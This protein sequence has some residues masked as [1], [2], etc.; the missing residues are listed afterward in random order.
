MKEIDF[1]DAV[2][3]V[4]RKY[5][6]ECITYKPPRRMN[7]WIRRMSTLAA[8]FLVIIGAVLIINH[9]NQPV[10]IDENGFYIED[11][12][13]LRYTGSETDVTIP[14]EV[15][16]IAD[17]TFL[18]N[19]NRT[20]IEVV[21]LG[22]S[23]QKVETNA[24]AGLENL[25]DIIIAANNLSFVEEDGLL[26]TSDK[27][28]LL[29]YKRQ[30]ETSF[31]IPESVRFVAAHAVQGTELEEIDFGNI[32]Y[33]GYYAFT[34]NYKLKEIQL[35][36][37]VKYIGEGAFSDCTSAVDGTIPADA[38]VSDHAFWRVPFYNSM[39]AG[40]M[41]PGEEIRRGLITPSEAIRK[42]DL[43]SLTE[44]L[45]YVLASIRG[46]TDYEPSEAAKFGTAAAMDAPSVPE[47]MI[48]PKSVSIDDLTFKDYG[49]SNTGI[50]DLQIN[51]PAGDY[52]IVIESYGYDPF[53]ELYWK[54]TRFRLV[55]LYYLKNEISSEDV[56][57]E[58]FGWTVIPEKDEKTFTGFTLIHE[59]GTVIHHN[60]SY[61]P[62]EPYRFLFSPNGTRL[63]VEYKHPMG[64]YSFY[65]LSLNGDMLDTAVNPSKETEYMHR[66][67]G[68][69]QGGTL[70]WVD[71]ENLEGVNIYGKFR[72]NLQDFYETKVTQLDEDPSLTDPDNHNTVTVCVYT[73][74]GDDIYLDIPETWRDR[75]SYYDLVRESQGLDP[76]RMAL[77]GSLPK[78]RTMSGGEWTPEKLTKAA[79]EKDG[80]QGS[81]WI[82]S[83][84][85][86]FYGTTA[87]D[88]SY[89]VIKDEFPG[90]FPRDEYAIALAY[91]GVMVHDIEFKT[92]PE[93]GENAFENIILPILESIIIEPEGIA[94]VVDGKFSIIPS[95]FSKS[96]SALPEAVEKA[97]ISSRLMGG[98][99]VIYVFDDN[100]CFYLANLNGDMSIGT[101]YSC[102]LSLPNGYT[103]GRIVDAEGRG[104]SGEFCIYVST[105][106]NG[107]T[108]TL[109]Y[110]FSGEGI[111][112]P[113]E[114]RIEETNREE[115]PIH[116]TFTADEFSAWLCKTGDANA[117]P[118]VPYTIQISGF[119]TP[120][121]FEMNG[122]ANPASITAYDRTVAITENAQ[123]YG[124]CTFD[125]FEADGA[126]I[127]SFGYYNIGH[128]YIL[129]K[130]STQ[131][132]APGTDNSIHLYPDDAGNLRYQ[133]INNRIADIIQ[134]GGL[135]AAT[136]YDDLLYCY[137]DASIV[138]GELVL[139]DVDEY[140][141]ISDK[142]DLDQEFENMYS[143]YHASIQEVFDSHKLYPGGAIYRPTVFEV[144]LTMSV[145]DIRSTYGTLTLE[146]SEHGPGQPVYSM[147]Y[148]P[149][150]L[151]VFHNWNMD[152]P[153]SD[154][155]I[156]A[157]LILTEN[158]SRDVRGITVGAN[159]E[160]RTQTIHWSDLWYH[161]INGT[162]NLQAEFSGYTATYTISGEN[163]NLPA[164]DTAHEFD[165][166]TWEAEYIQNP[167]G[168]IVEI[169]I[170]LNQ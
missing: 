157:E 57:A 128:T 39:L 37:S 29:Q 99:P 49:W 125:L 91:Q 21:R 163:L 124:N 142:Y 170:K 120:V 158:C 84:S 48:V 32:E 56:A 20:K 46:D 52:T 130:D 4:D 144:L 50:Y 161:V 79:M 71:D 70:C 23:V 2:G 87:H 117:F 103:Y 69:Y 145:A 154:N 137:G 168:R 1:L 155:M 10:I 11:G 9:M 18:E 160:D 16:T 164:E 47:G 53:D 109:A 17:F 112:Q 131:T 153:L 147:K 45:T 82:M 116:Y 75:G 35:P 13:L 156:P 102:T 100:L 67:Y 122:Y 90:E 43:Y 14:E 113:Y 60:C 140:Y 65:I 61:R 162:A 44:Q 85:K 62:T 152:D 127:F 41:C 106:H 81:P 64:Y 76:V 66:Y 98:S 93:D 118:T 72:F 129:T 150:V 24:F 149:G 42:S 27:S 121:V 111:P 96:I 80:L 141:T 73:L 114:V 59:D 15:E 3:R 34:G 169:R 28:I 119:D 31:T 38:E 89:M 5:I 165:W 88:V 108:V 159:I 78:D 139:Q 19:T 107:D 151:L 63:A 132:I 22:A 166:D 104:G 101:L 30:G 33:I 148:L 68:E 133:R 138:D 134:T 25:V 77:F 36:D 6:E 167:T 95:C 7:V 136:G 143:R 54:E 135:S 105:K 12:V 126:I 86:I 51:I 83:E 115:A 8:C 123:L 40:Q 26:M 58:E 55:N 146:Y 94:H 74:Y 110:L 97:R 92:Y